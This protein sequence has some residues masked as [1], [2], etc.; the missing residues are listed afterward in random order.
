MWDQPVR[1]IYT[2]T[3]IHTSTRVLGMYVCLACMCVWHVWQPCWEHTHMWDQLVRYTYMWDQPVRYIHTYTHIHTNTRVFGICTKHMLHVY[4]W[5]SFFPH[6]YEI[7]FHSIYMDLLCPCINMCIYVCLHTDMWVF[8]AELVSIFVMNLAI[9]SNY[10]GW[11][12]PVGVYSLGRTVLLLGSL[13][14]PVWQFSLLLERMDSSTVITSLIEGVLQGRPL[15]DCFFQA[16]EERA[17]LFDLIFPELSQPSTEVLPSFD[18]TFLPT[19]NNDFNNQW[20]KAWTELATVYSNVICFLW[21]IS[22]SQIMLRHFVNGTLCSCMWTL[23]WLTAILQID[24]WK[25]NFLLLDLVWAGYVGGQCFL[26]HIGDFPFDCSLAFGSLLSLL[27][28]TT[29]LAYYTVCVWCC[30]YVHN[31]HISI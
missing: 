3:H 10:W 19:Q 16:M 31:R 23:W 9:A 14:L 1:Y 21:L 13:I 6:T 22:F 25:R 11:T 20:A 30:M 18:S 27:L 2:Y 7:H 28:W 26:Y 5:D 24:F 12:H 4:K 17:R 8:W 15:P 29:R